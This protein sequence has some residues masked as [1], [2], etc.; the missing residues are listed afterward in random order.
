[1]FEG[2]KIIDLSPEL[3]PGR[4]DR[5]LET[6]EYIFELDNTY[7]TDID[8]M[9]HIGIHVEGPSHYKKGLKEIAEL[10]VETFL[11]EAVCLDVETVGKGG[12]ITPDDLARISRTGGVKPHDIL[13]LHS[14][15]TGD[16]I[17]YISRDLAAWMADLPVKM[18]GIDHTVALEEKG[19][20]FTHDFLLGNDIPVIERVA[21]LDKVPERFFFI[22]LPLRIRAM[23]SSPIRGIAVVK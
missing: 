22:G 14:P 18:L 17:P 19:R 5:R 1:M 6:R 10:P 11:G 21:N 9:S 7:M 20:M 23:D 15:F 4:E 8:M 16:D 12:S 2:C 3:V 13:F